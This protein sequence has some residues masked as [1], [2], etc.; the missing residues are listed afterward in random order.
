MDIARVLTQSVMK[1]ATGNSDVCYNIQTAVDAKNKLIV[2]FGLC[3]KL[4]Q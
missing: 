3:P 1:Q 2:D 4:M